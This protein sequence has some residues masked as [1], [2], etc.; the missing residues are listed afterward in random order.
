MHYLLN[1]ID[2]RVTCQP[3]D[4]STFEID[5]GFGHI[6]SYTNKV[7]YGTRPHGMADNIFSGSNVCDMVGRMGF[8]AVIAF[9]QV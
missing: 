2:A 6:R 3:E 4:Q 1:A 7:I 8:G 5:D 9:Q